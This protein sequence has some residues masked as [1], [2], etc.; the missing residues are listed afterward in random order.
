MWTWMLNW[1]EIT[2]SILVGSCPMTPSDL[3]RISFEA[4]ASGVL[5]LQHDECLSFWRIDYQEMLRA[6]KELGMRMERCQIRD[7]DVHDMRRRLPLA[8]SLLADML[9]SGHRVYVHCT[10][11]VGRAPLAV[12]G[13]LCLMEDYPQEMAVRIIQRGRHAAQPSST[14]LEGCLED[15]TEQNL[16]AIGARAYEL[17]KKGYSKD[18]DRN[19]L[20]AR[21][22]VLRSVLSSSGLRF[23]EEGGGSA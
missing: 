23:P 15:L 8:V 17:H 4:R 20:K 14:A 2:D 18:P 1:G 22:E 12:L 19:W 6:G 3:R 9:S 10:A 11:G 16:S 13:Y 21:S 5:S 7:F